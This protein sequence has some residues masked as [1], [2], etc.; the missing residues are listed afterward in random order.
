MVKFEVK[1]KYGYYWKQNPRLSH[2]FWNSGHWLDLHYIE[3]ERN[4]LIY[5]R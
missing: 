2:I 5:T 4:K 3:V 1:V